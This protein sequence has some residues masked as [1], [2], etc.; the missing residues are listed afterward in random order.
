MYVGRSAILSHWGDLPS[1]IELSRK[2]LD[3]M[4]TGGDSVGIVSAAFSLAQA[5]WYSGDL[6]DARQMLL[7]NLSHARGESGQQRSTATFVLPSVVFFCYLAR[8]SSDL[9]DS[10]AG[11]D[12]IK[13][14]AHDRRQ[15][16]PYLRSAAGGQLRRRLVAGERAADES[17]E[18]L[19]SALAVARA[20]ELEWHMPLIAC[21]LGRAYVDGGHPANARK[22]L[23]HGSTLA[24]RNRQVA[25]RLLCGPPLIRALAEGPDGDLPAAKDLA[26]LTLRD[27][28]ARGFRPIVVQTQLALAHV[29]TLQGKPGRRRFCAMPRR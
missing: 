22:L 6:Q 11:F 19:E 17:T 3:I 4:R 8:I 14:A 24:D 18:M 26:A 12:A 27:A 25:K 5:L 21:L 7:S 13:E 15:A 1:A 29:H 9:G 23:E 2:A 16:W 10:A 28:S 20:N